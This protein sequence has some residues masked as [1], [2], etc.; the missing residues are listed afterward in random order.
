[1][2]KVLIDTDSG[3]VLQ[4]SY[5][6]LEETNDSEFLVI[7]SAS[8]EYT[9]NSDVEIN[10]FFEL[11]AQYGGNAV[12]KRINNF[13]VLITDI[14]EY[15]SASHQRLLIMQPDIDTTKFA[16]GLEALRLIYSTP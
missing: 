10:E 13:F 11:T 3:I 8:Y 2:L 4:H 15:V 16:N 9:T 7:E 5:N 12:V 1:M 14:E 6:G